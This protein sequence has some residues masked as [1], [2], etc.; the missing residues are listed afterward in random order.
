MQPCLDYC[1]VSWYLG[2]SV[3][4]RKKLDVIQ[5][6]MARIVLGVGPRTH[7]GTGLVDSVGQSEIFFTASCSQGEMGLGPILSTQG[8]CLGDGCL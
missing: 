7:V 3:A 2:L 4:S 5:R 8:P 1:I 6:K